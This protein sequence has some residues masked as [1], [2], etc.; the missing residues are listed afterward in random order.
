[1]AQVTTQTERDVLT[2]T[3]GTYTLEEL[4]AAV[5]AAGPHVTH[6]DDGQDVVHGLSDTRWKRRVRGALQTLK[7]DGR[8]RRVGDS[9]WVLDGTPTSPRRALLVSLSGTHSQV[10]LRLSDAESLLRG[11]DEPA[12]LILTD[13]PYGLGVGTGTKTDTGARTYARDSS[14]VMGG[15]IDVPSNA[16]R[17]FTA[18][19][20]TAAAGALRPG[21]YLAVVTGPQQ[22]AYVQVAAEDAGLTYVN[23]IAVGKIFGLRTTRRFAHSHWTVTVMCS[24]QLNSPA[25]VFTPPPDL[26]TARSGALYPL[27]HWEIGSVGRADA[28]RGALRYPNSLPVRMVDRLVG[29]FTRPE[30]SDLVCDPFVGGGTT[31]LV[32]LQRRLRFIG[33]DLNPSALAFT[34]ARISRELHSQQDA[35]AGAPLGNGQQQLW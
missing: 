32:A 1:M 3:H 13:P 11:L 9:M 24:G 20:I 25:R 27:D 2:E 12:D 15:Y 22:A 5:E 17:D 10:E 35:A 14:R 28:A 23:A 4:Y 31:A 33:G 30:Q 26:P 7:K 19:W 18:T 21:G 16:Y 6:R 29:A 34:A 8:A